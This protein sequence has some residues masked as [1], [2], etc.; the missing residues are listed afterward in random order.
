MKTAPNGTLL[1]EDTEARV[2]QV[3]P[4]AELSN[5]GVRFRILSQ[6]LTSFKEYVIRRLKREIAYRE[7]WAVKDVSLRAYAGECLGIIGHNG[8]G[9]ST[10]LKVLARVIRPTEG[11]V[12]VRGSVAPLLELNAGFH[13]DLTG[14]ENVFLNGTLLGYSKKDIARAF[15]QVVDFAEL[16]EFIEMPVRTY[17]YGMLLRLGFAVATAFRPDILLVD[18]II[19]VGDVSFRQKCLERMETFL[20]EGTTI[21]LVSHNLETIRRLCH[22]VIWLDHGRIRM[23]GDPPE[24]VQ[25]YLESS[26]LK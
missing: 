20:S 11:R 16:R 2:S 14:R 18:E 3:I 26:Q 9:K 10:L 17:S 23:M 8:A 1:S 7:F 6:P 12:V 5:V 25:A 24:V 21:I 4:V 19:A 15:Q 13:M 22:R